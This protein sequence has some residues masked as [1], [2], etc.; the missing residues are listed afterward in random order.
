MKF[1]LPSISAGFVLGAVLVLVFG[2]PNEG[3][4]KNVVKQLPVYYFSERIPGFAGGS[5]TWVLKGEEIANKYNAANINCFNHYGETS[6]EEIRNR[7]I[8]PE[9]Y[10]YI[11][12]ADIF[13]GS[14]SADLSLFTITEWNEKRVVAE[15]V[16][17]CRKVTM[18]LDRESKTITQL[19]TLLAGASDVDFCEGLS[20][21]PI[22][23][24][25]TDGDRVINP[26]N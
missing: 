3:E 21:D 6:L 9:M 17:L 12:Q 1:D 4:N 8:E 26:S 19:A 7:G 14:L 2:T 10:C 5:G 20:S 18:T 11:A 22:Q 15:S 24:F 13:D 16:G 23:S 25:L